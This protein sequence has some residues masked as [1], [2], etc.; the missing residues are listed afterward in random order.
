MFENEEFE[1]NQSVLPDHLKDLSF[2][3]VSAGRPPVHSEHWE[4]REFQTRVKQDI[5]DSF[6]AGH[7]KSRVISP[8]GSGKTTM[9]VDVM[10]QL[11]TPTLILAPGIAAVDRFYKELVSRGETP[12]LLS[13]ANLHKLGS[14]RFVICT[15]QTLMPTKSREGLM[16]SISEDHFKHLWVDEA[17]HFFG[18]KMGQVPARFNAFHTYITATPD[19]SSKSLANVAPHLASE[20]KYQELVDKHGYPVRRLFTHKITGENWDKVRVVAN[21][22]KFQDGENGEVKGLNMPARYGALYKTITGT[23]TCKSPGIAFMPSIKSSKHF[24][25]R[26]IDSDPKL[27]GKVKLVSGD[28]SKKARN[29]ILEEINRGEL[30][31]VLTTQAWAESVDIPRLKHVVMVDNTAAAWLSMQRIGRGTRKHPDKNNEVWIHDLVSHVSNGGKR[32]ASLIRSLKPKLRNR[33]VRQGMCLDDADLEPIPQE[34]LDSLNVTTHEI[35]L[36]DWAYEIDFSVLRDRPDISFQLLKDFANS[37]GIPPLELLLNAEAYLKRDEYIECN[38]QNEENLQLFFRDLWNFIQLYQLKDVLAD[39]AFHGVDALTESFGSRIS[40]VKG[41]ESA[42][43]IDAGM[44]KKHFHAEKLSDSNRDNFVYVHEWQRR[45]LNAIQFEFQAFDEEFFY[46]FNELRQ[47][48][49]LSDR[50]YLEFINNL[51]EFQMLA[52]INGI[53]IGIWPE[54]QL[55]IY[56][57][58]LYSEPV[59]LWNDDARS[60]RSLNYSNFWKEIEAEVRP[61][62]SSDFYEKLKSAVRAGSSYLCISSEEAPDFIKDI[63]F[64][65]FL[66]KEESLNGNRALT[67]FR[68]KNGDWLIPLHYLKYIHQYPWAEPE[69]DHELPEYTASQVSYEKIWEF[70]KNEIA[71]QNYSVC[72]GAIK[73]E[74]SRNDIYDAHVA[75]PVLRRLCMFEDFVKELKGKGIN[76]S[77]A[78]NR[79]IN[80]GY[81]EDQIIKPETITLCIAPADSGINVQASIDSA[82]IQKLISEA[83]PLPKAGTSP[84]FMEALDEQTLLT[85]KSITNLKGFHLKRELSAKEHAMHWLVKN[86]SCH[87]GSNFEY[88]DLMLGLYRAFQ[89]IEFKRTLDQRIWRGIIKRYDLEVFETAPDPDSFYSEFR[90]PAHQLTEVEKEFL[91]YYAWVLQMYGVEYHFKNNEKGVSRTARVES[92]L[93]CNVEASPFFR[94]KKDENGCADFAS[95]PCEPFKQTPT[96]KKYLGLIY[97]ALEKGEKTV[98]LPFYTVY[99]YK[100]LLHLQNAFYSHG[101]WGLC[102]RPVKV[103]NCWVVV[104]LEGLENAIEK[105][106][107]ASGLIGRHTSAKKIGDHDFILRHGTTIG[108]RNTEGYVKIRQEGQ[109]IEALH[110]TA[111]APIQEE[112]QKHCIRA[113]DLSA[114]THVAQTRRIITV[115]SHDDSHGKSVWRKTLTSACPPEIIQSSG[116]FVLL[117]GWGKEADAWLD[118]GVHEGRLILV[119]REEANIPHLRRRYPFATVIHGDICT[120]RTWSQIRRG[121]PIAGVSIDPYAGATKSFIDPLRR[122]LRRTVLTDKLYLSLNLQGKIRGNAASQKYFESVRARKKLPQTTGPIELAWHAVLPELYKVPVGKKLHTGHYFGDSHQTRMSCAMGLAVK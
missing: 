44:A 65:L 56:L 14:A 12:L 106:P 21:E 46:P 67:C 49:S 7:L 113:I 1:I 42:S 55:V 98:R 115:A 24:I 37:F 29:A 95:P 107:K 100:D 6:E 52:S 53:E 40:D 121:G 122:G 62:V 91:I 69:T 58:D 57:S 83:I 89:N 102:I 77:W 13:K 9:A 20:V 104:S 3:H 2:E 27:K 97:A 87:V 73:F 41:P 38:I 78:Y 75:H 48:T 120:Q 116:R 64:L 96:S 119:D 5:L 118:A 19:T 103:H 22:V 108:V 92:H 81:G 105:A 114:A 30:L 74:F 43:P 35:H 66:K 33:R 110:Q 61:H 60:L 10:I 51:E 16:M 99:S 45:L 32:A 86:I 72:D 8:T 71:Q 17:H 23:M 76:A 26:F 34:I 68:K 50:E 70:L 84:E 54:N 28:M 80:E 36:S 59:T 101:V 15:G 79:Y 94:L 31:C 111:L 39:Q 93:H 82:P 25:K 18:K 47:D 63:H 4:E 85:V 88:A 117:P 109:S 112:T 90:N 11:E